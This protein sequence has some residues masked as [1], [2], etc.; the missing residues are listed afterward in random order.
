MVGH[1]KWLEMKAVFPEILKISWATS[2]NFTDCGVFL[3]RHMEMYFGSKGVK[4]DCGFPKNEKEKKKKIDNLRIKYACRMLTSET[5]IHREKVI[6]EAAEL[7]MY[8]NNLK[9]KCG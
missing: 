4:F 1:P 9:K 7:E 6:K 8:Q 5:N 3:M 2:N